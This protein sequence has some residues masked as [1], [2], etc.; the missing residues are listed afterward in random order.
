MPRRIYTYPS[1]MGWD[2]SNLLTTIG[3]FVFGIGIVMFVINA[4]V[5]ARRGARAGDN[6]W[7]RRA[8][9]GRSRRRRPPTTSRCCR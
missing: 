1:G 5:S 6:P 4:L 8:S 2:T 7:G 3:S 9:N